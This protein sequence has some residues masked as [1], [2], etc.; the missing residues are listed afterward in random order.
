MK[1][2]ETR[3][4]PCSEGSQAIGQKSTH[5]MAAPAYKGAQGRHRAMHGL[6]SSLPE[7]Y[8]AQHG[9]RNSIKQRSASMYSNESFPICHR[10]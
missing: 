9:L 4:R 8:G 2:K 10:P 5:S 1:H 7:K 3:G 6:S